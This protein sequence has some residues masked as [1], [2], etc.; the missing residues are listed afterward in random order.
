[1]VVAKSMIPQPAPAR[2]HL[3]T[4]VTLAAIHLLACAAFFPQLF[5][6]PAVM[7]A[8]VLY[9]VIG[10]VGI[11]LGY[12]RILTHRSARIPRPLEYAIATLG[13]LALEGGPITWVATHRVHHLYSDTP[14]DPHNARRGFLWAHM[15][16][17]V[18]PNP[19]RPT[20]EAVNKYAADLACDPYYRWL[21]RYSA[22]L[23]LPLALALFAVGGFSWLVWGMFVRLVFSYHCTWLVNSAAHS[24]G[25]RTYDTGDL[26]TNNWWVAL[27]AWG[28]GWHNNHHAFPSS[29]RHGLRWYELDSTWLTIRLLALARIA[30][31]VRVPTAAMLER[32]P[33]LKPR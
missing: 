14:A 9:Y 31:R 7:V 13:A 28:E 16:W 17:L 25:Y 33:M 30:T 8:A 12:H 27:L 18:V 20:E 11:C 22:W 32:G 10:A 3:V 2:P 26:S 24:I 29:A 1:M 4:A 6:W 15:L 19:A 21:E 23:Q 5:S